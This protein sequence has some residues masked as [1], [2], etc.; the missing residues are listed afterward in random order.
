MLLSEQPERTEQG[1]GFAV[2]AAQ[3]QKLAEQSNSS[4]SQIQGIINSLIEDSASAVKTMEE[5]KACNGK[6]K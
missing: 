3:I 2:V 5:I 4:A 1:K 6:T